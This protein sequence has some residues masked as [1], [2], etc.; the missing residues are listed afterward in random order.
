M[1]GWCR[2]VDLDAV[3][4]IYPG[5]CPLHLVSRLEG[6]NPLPQIHRADLEV[7]CSMAI[8]LTGLAQPQGLSFAHSSSSSLLESL[9]W[10]G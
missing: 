4:P 9:A 1:G 10:Q 3:A 6:G 2:E 8:L 5:H 7:P